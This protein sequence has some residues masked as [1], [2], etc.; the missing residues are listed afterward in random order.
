MVIVVIVSVIVVI[1]VIVLVIVVTVVIVYRIRI[2]SSTY[3]LYAHFI[4]KTSKKSGSESGHDRGFHH[5]V[6][7]LSW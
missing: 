7:R 5:H 3:I 2:I 1:V 6:T 4:L